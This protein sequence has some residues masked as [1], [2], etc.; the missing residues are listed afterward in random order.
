MRVHLGLK[1]PRDWNWLGARDSAHSFPRRCSHG[2][3]CKCKSMSAAF[4]A[5]GPAFKENFEGKP[6]ESV[7]LYPLMCKILGIQPLPNNGS[8]DATAD[9]LAP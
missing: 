1:L 6:F 7:S 2:F 4:I 5:L 9:L 3:S 8:L